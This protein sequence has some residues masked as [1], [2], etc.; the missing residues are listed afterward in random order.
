MSPKV[1]CQKAAAESLEK[2]LCGYNTKLPKDQGPRTRQKAKKKM[3][4]P[5]HTAPS[6]HD[7]HDREAFRESLS[8]ILG[9]Q[10]NPPSRG[11]PSPQTPANL[12]YTLP[13]HTDIHSRKTSLI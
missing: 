5:L 4:L 6:H 12:L 2:W 3:D 7:T 13:K 9:K 10:R 8:R 1:G 11:H